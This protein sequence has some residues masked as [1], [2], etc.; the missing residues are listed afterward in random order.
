MKKVLCIL[1]SL[2][3]TLS[4][5]CISGFAR[6]ADAPDLCIAVASDLH[7]NVARD[8][9]TEDIPGEEIFWYANRRAQMEDESGFIIDEFLR[10]C[11][12]NDS[13]EYVLIAGDMADNGRTIPQ[14]H[15]DVAAKLKAFEEQ[16]GKSV[17]VINGNHDN[18]VKSEGV[19]GIEDIIEI[20]RDFGYDEALDTLEGTCSYTANLGEKYRLIALDSCNASVSTEDGLTSDRVQWVKKMAK[21]AYD[22]GR[23]PIVMMH[24]NLLDHMPLQR[25]LSHDFI[26]R[27]H[28]ATATKFAD[29]G[30]KVVLSGHEHCSDA[31]SYTSPSGNTIY[32]F[33]NTSL[34]MFPIAYRVMSFSDDE[35]KYENKK[36]ESIDVDALTEVCDGFTEEQISFMKN[37]FEGYSKGF[38]KAGIKYRLSLSLSKEKLGID[39]D[40]FYAD[41]VYTAVFGL[42][43]LLEMPLYGEGGVQ[44]LA[45]EFNIDIPDVDYENGWDLATDLVS[46]HYAGSEPFNLESPEVITLL[47]MVDL[48]L[49]QDLSNVNDKVFLKSANALLE[50]LGTS[51]IC[52]DFTRFCTKI[53]GPVTA[54]EYFLLAVASPLLYVFA[55]D[56]DGVDD[57]NGFVPGYGTVTAAQRS[58]DAAANF[59]SILEKLVTYFGFFITYFLRIFRINL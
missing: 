13:V 12:E 56:S 41:L 33:A 2:V 18:G 11:A 40:A 20:Y 7:Y 10:Q 21:K 6:E 3:I 26:V 43:D 22:E 48:I 50:N 53:F 35:I 47:R 38:L 14:E 39:E 16:T 44:E 1:L 58:A 51:T 49:L 17:Y 34:T 25:I 9:I 19:T 54:G 37:D 45:K 57:N 4:A 5:V 46:W 15:H 28:T 36:I 30:I 52:G 42:T 31:T 24:H 23:Y 59:R 27:N 8:V 55:S 32:D 29:W